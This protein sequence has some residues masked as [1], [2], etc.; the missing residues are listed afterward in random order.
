MTCCAVLRLLNCVA[1]VL[2]QTPRHN[3][4]LGDLTDLFKATGDMQAVRA[5]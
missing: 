1:Q 3:Y 2:V 4:T 5:G